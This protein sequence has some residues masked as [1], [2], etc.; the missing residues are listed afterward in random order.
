MS[1]NVS[2]PRNAAPGIGKKFGLLMRAK[3]VK[4]GYRV[5]MFLYAAC[6]FV[7]RPFFA[8]SALVKR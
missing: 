7:Y 1:R 2:T 6:P 4:L 3:R 8:L 5:R